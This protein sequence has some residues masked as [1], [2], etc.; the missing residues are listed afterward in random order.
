MK[1]PTNS[2]ER[3]FIEYN[4]STRRSKNLKISKNEKGI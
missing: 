1:C 2:G 3:E 4:V